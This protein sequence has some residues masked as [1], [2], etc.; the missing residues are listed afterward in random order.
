MKKVLIGLEVILNSKAP[1]AVI[2]ETISDFSPLSA[3]YLHNKFPPAE[4]PTAYY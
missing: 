1:Q 4:N 2:P 3:K